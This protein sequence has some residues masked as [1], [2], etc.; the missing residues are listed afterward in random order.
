MKARGR[1]IRDLPAMGVFGFPHDRPGVPVVTPHAGESGSVL[2]LF[3]GLATSRK[4]CGRRLR[5]AARC[6]RHRTRRDDAFLVRTSSHCAGGDP[7][8]IAVSPSAS[9]K[10]KTPA[11]GCSSSAAGSTS[12][13]TLIGEEPDNQS[14]ARL[15]PGG[16]RRPGVVGRP[17]CGAVVPGPGVP[18]HRR[19]GVPGQ[20][21]YRCICRPV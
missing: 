14:A 21:S 16:R 18:G 1:D 13:P 20:W 6:H 17:R 12:H 8:P 9:E 15:V 10:E 19:R 4:P 5:D 7:N 3:V 2:P 11:S